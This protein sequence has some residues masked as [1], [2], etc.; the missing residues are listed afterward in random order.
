MTLASQMLR[1]SSGR[2]P[3][4]WKPSDRHGFPVR[5]VLGMPMATAQPD[6]G[7]RL[8]AL[9]TGV[10]SSESASVIPSARLADLSRKPAEPFPPT[11]RC[12]EW[13]RAA[14]VPVLSNTAGVPIAGSI[15]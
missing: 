5:L 3:G 6:L 4:A 14:I 1:A 15:C 12:G 7:D 2:G 8:Y 13:V 11:K 9:N 10:P